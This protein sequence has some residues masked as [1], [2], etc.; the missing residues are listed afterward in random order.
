MAVEQFRD[1]RHPTNS[2]PIAGISTGRFEVED[3]ARKKDAI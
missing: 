3:L 2:T 1:G